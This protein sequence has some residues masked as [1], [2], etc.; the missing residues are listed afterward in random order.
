[1]FKNK[2]L[3]R[4]LMMIVES[5]LHEFIGEDIDDFP[6][7]IDYTAS[8]EE[9]YNLL[10]H[11]FNDLKESYNNQ[12]G[13]QTEDIREIF[14]FAFVEFFDRCVPNEFLQ[15]ELTE[16]MYMMVIKRAR[17]ISLE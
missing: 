15:T 2:Q 16:D 1:M 5:K 14:R 7:L 3:D 17:K 6:Y 9:L 8:E 13:R 11:D 4:L 12:V 10:K